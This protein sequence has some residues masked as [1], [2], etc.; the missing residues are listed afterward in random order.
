MCWY[1]SN[2]LNV[3]WPFGI[4]KA[5]AER[6]A[7][8]YCILCSLL[9]TVQVASS[10]GLVLGI[11][12]GLAGHNAM[13]TSPG[14]CW[15]AYFLIFSLISSVVVHQKYMNSMLEHH[16]VSVVVPIHFLLWSGVSITLGMSLFDETS[17]QPGV[18]I[19]LFTAGL[20]LSFAAVYLINSGDRQQADSRVPSSN[21]SSSSSQDMIKSSKLSIVVADLILSSPASIPS[22]KLG[23][24]GSAGNALI[25]QV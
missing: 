3:P 17:F 24:L 22:D 6:N 13:F 14:T 7:V 12:R 9:G 21:T 5:M 8:Y 25:E 16:D 10:R 1:I 23:K 15:L 19:P 4:S 2:P 11:T 20:A 18:G